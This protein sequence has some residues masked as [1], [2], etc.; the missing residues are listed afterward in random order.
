[1]RRARQWFE[2]LAPWAGLVVGLVAFSVVHQF[3]SDGTFNDCDAASPGPVLIVALLGVL[4]CA[5][6][7]FASWRGMRGSGNESRRVMA[8]VSIG[9]GVLFVF[10][11]LLA[12]IATLVLPPCFA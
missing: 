3:G 5:G 1:M 7:A 11:I 8:V 2:A 10:G 12:M 9:L 6:S 4:A